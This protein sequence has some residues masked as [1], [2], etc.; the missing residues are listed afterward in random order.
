MND[1]FIYLNLNKISYLYTLKERGLHIGEE[2]NYIL[3]VR[4]GFV[5][6]LT[7]ELDSGS[8]IDD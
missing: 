6:L 8:W 5:E 3:S 7:V 4:E 2:R 1:T